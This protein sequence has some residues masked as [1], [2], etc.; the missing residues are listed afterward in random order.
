[1][2]EQPKQAD[3]ETDQ[4]EST[5]VLIGIPTY[6]EEIA[7]GSVIHKCYDAHGKHVV[8]FQ[9]AASRAC[10]SASSPGFL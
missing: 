1:M 3:S 4:A 7:I 9:S 10:L 8:D 2:L 6:N 5:E